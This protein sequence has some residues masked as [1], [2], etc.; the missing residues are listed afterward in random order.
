MKASFGAHLRLDILSRHLGT[1]S[2]SKALHGTKALLS[3][4]PPLQGSGLA[5][6]SHCIRIRCQA[7]FLCACRIHP[8]L[9]ITLCSGVRMWV[10]PRVCEY[11][12]AC[13]HTSWCLTIIAMPVA[14]SIA[15]LN[16]QHNWGCSSRCASKTY[17][18]VGCVRIRNS[19]A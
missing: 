9:I 7:I 13:M 15:W 16:L 18:C 8:H 6:Q 17:Y 14:C 11:V 2:H 12:C 3:C 5:Y 10:L 4:H 1:L 19:L